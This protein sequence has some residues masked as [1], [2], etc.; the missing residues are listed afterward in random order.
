MSAA[1]NWVKNHPYI[2]TAGVVIVAAG[3]YNYHENQSVY[4]IVL[5]HL[6]SLRNR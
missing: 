6:T 5:S 2:T 3:I 1:W 4:Q